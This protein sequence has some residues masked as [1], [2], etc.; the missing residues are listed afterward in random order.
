MN[1]NRTNYEMYM[2]DYLDG[3]L[4]AIEVSE[5]LLFIEQHP[6]IKKEFDLLDTTILSAEKD[7]VDT[8]FLK[9]PVYADIKIEFEEKLIAYLEGDLNRSEKVDLEKAFILYPELKTDSELFGRTKINPETSI[10]LENKQTLKKSVPLFTSYQ[11][12]LWRAAAVLVVSGLM[13]FFIR[14]PQEKLVTVKSSVEPKTSV[15]KD[16]FAHESSTR[17]KENTVKIATDIKIHRNKK[18]V[19]KK[20]EIPSANQTLHFET[21]EE[22]EP[23]QIVL[24]DRKDLINSLTTVTYSAKKESPNTKEELHF[25][26]LAQFAEINLN[27]T[28]RDVLVEQNKPDSIV[29]NS[30][31]SNIGLLFVKLYN[32]TTGDDAKIVKKYNNSGKVIGYAIVANNFQFAT[33][34]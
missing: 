24:N 33:G 19:L 27:N 26:E 30:T 13:F 6:D 11:N 15:G 23:Q 20:R 9:K 8:S 31:I 2:I 12:Y 4:T 14:T 10:I 18:Y 3:K 1:I 29:N 16:H 7:H 22:M 34:K 25:P 5:L 21:I 28:T 32:K 17:P